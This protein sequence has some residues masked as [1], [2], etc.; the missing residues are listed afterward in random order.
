MVGLPMTEMS[1]PSRNCA[2]GFLF[3]ENEMD[4]NVLM[5]SG[6][7][8]LLAALVVL[9]VVF[10]AKRVKLAKSGDMA[11]L[12][13]LLLSV[14]VSG[15]ASDPGKLENQI[16]MVVCALASAALHEIFTWLASKFPDTSTSDQT[17]DPELEQGQGMVEYALIL[18]LVA[19]VVIAAL[20]IMG[21]LVANV[22]STINSSLV[23]PGS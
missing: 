3:K 14:L 2:T 20:T 5:Q 9:V 8:G 16:I 6:L 18:V 17:P 1:H 23:I 21:P 15:V 7:Y 22:F 11:R 10:I 4:I 13:N 19:V 12:L